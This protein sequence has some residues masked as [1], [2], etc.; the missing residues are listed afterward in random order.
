MAFSFA[1]T[2]SEAQA[3]AASLPSLSLALVDKNLPDGSGLDVIR[4]IRQAHPAAEVIMVTAYASLSSA[5]EAMEAGACDY[6]TKPFELHHLELRVNNALEKAR[7]KRERAE[8]EER[9][10]RLFEGASE[11]IVVFEEGGAAVDAN[12][13]AFTMYGHSLEAF[14]RLTEPD[15]LAPTPPDVPSST[16]GALPWHRRADGSL[17]PAE[18]QRRTIPL[19][20]KEVTV[21]LVRDVSRRLELEEQLRHSQKMNAIGRLAGGIAHD[22]NNLLTIILAYAD[23]LAKRGEGD[24]TLH[25]YARE[26]VKAGERAASL[27][28]QLLSFSR[29]KHANPQV[30]SIG[31]C[32]RDMEGLLQR[33]LGE[34]VE[35]VTVLAHKTWTV[36]AD[37]DHLAQIL[38]NLAVNARD[39]MPEG[40]RL[41]LRARNADD[42]DRTAIVGA[43]LDGTRRYACLEV[44]DTGVGIPPDVLSQIFEPFFT[45]KQIGLG[46]GLGLSV[47]YGLLQQSGGAVRVESQVGKGTSFFVYLPAA[48][49]RSSQAEASGPHRGTVLLVEDDHAVRQLL[50]RLLSRC[51][52]EV[53]EASSGKEAL[54]RLKEYD[55]ELDLLITDVRMPGMSGPALVQTLREQFAEVG[56]VYISGYPT[57]EDLEAEAERGAE[58]LTKPFTREALHQALERTLPRRRKAEP[59]GGGASGVLEG[60]LETEQE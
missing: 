32:I 45:T 43:G 47:V 42:V 26:I 40:G 17:F 33:T 14:R 55:G 30:V 21:L 49:D 48:D 13:A 39:A 23:M 6:L 16:E 38:L 4:A 35:L 60:A 1:F 10:R 51:G 9:Y 46:T 54:A 5:I 22:F 24:A 58:F 12:A 25:G 57:G 18:V 19:Q 2:A 37:E 11:A 56:V 31:D 28:R 44:T 15:L 8:S 53:I 27:T 7:L 52:C 50:C 20:G 36:H 41:T 29:K 59:R 34:E 3:Q